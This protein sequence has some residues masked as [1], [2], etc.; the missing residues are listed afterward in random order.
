MQRNG[1]PA[2]LEY[3]VSRLG[4]AI[5]GDSCRRPPPPE[6]NTARELSSMFDYVFDAGQ[7]AVGRIVP[8]SF[9]FFT[10]A[11]IRLAK[12]TGITRLARLTRERCPFH[13]IFMKN[14]RLGAR[15]GLG[16]RTLLH[17]P[18]LHRPVICNIPIITTIHIS[19]VHVPAVFRF[20]GDMNHTRSVRMGGT[21][22]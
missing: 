4:T 16:C 5:N 20:P 12:T 18:L 13:V 21:H 6:W 15:A 7:K 11:N 1:I 3:I 22:L 17:S 2:T 19:L 8:K 14:Y 9:D 10:A